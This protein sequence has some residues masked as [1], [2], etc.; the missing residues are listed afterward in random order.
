MPGIDT[1]TPNMARMYD[2]ALG[3]KDNFA[4]DREAVEKLFSF[5]PENRDVPRANRRFLGR[6][7]R[8][9]AA[10]GVRQ[11][12]DLGTG[13]PS[14]G[15]VHEIVAEINPDARVVYVDNDPVVVNH[16]QALLLDS[17]SVTAVQA[18]IRDPGSILAHPGVTGLIDFSQPA[19]VLFV[20]VLHGI[21]DR[22]DPA[23]I[24]RAFARRLSPGSYLI[25]SHLT[26]E[27]HPP[28][29]VA[30]KEEVFARSNAPVAY[31]S[32][33]EILRM[34]DGFT[35]V[36]P[37]LTAVTQW[38]GDEWDQHLDAAGQWWLGGVGY[39]E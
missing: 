39:A 21:P 15:H 1:R 26:S 38:R 6:A 7:V 27:G 25:L 16:A 30:Q 24:V 11:F 14:Q 34:F 23:G 37:G 29:L 35:L 17:A 10:Q 13:L 4:A 28:E 9:A 19:A 22:D 12:L 2:Y 36:E 31:R 20:A 33:A 8:F 18:D 5:S 3:G 32:R